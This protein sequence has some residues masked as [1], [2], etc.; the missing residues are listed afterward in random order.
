MRA[1]ASATTDS[2]AAPE[3][4]PSA[5]VTLRGARGG[6]WT[7]STG[8]ER[9]GAD[10]PPSGTVS[11]TVI[12]LRPPRVPTT[13]SG[14]TSTLSPGSS[15][16]AKLPSATRPVP[17]SP[18]PSC[19]CAAAVTSR[20]QSLASVK[21]SGPDVRQR[22]ATPQ[23]TIPSPRRSHAMGSSVG[24]SS[25]REAGS[26]GESSSVVRAC[27]RTRRPSAASAQGEVTLTRL[28]ERP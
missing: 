3:T 13:T 18:T 28:R 10:E 24:S 5:K 11:T 16:K 25:T 4:A 17:G 2:Q 23:A 6:A 7:S 20:H 15:A 14:T 21:R 22:A 8:A 19:T 9:T 27:S 26:E 12:Q 1:T